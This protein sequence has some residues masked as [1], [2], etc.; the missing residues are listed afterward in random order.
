MIKVVQIHGSM[1]LAP[2][3]H[4]L[5]PMVP[6]SQSHI[7]DPIVHILG[8]VP[9]SWPHGP[10]FPAPFYALSLTLFFVAVKMCAASLGSRARWVSHTVLTSLPMLRHFVIDLA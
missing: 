5:G 6:H 9:C 8:A 10:M 7:P 1:F 4:V 2:W 3:S